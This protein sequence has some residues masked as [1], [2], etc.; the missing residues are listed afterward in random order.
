MGRA[1]FVT[2]VQTPSHEPPGRAFE[3]NE[4]ASDEGDRKLSHASML[5]A[6][7]DKYAFDATIR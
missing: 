4:A 6:L 5:L 7:S 2:G 3:H 1:V